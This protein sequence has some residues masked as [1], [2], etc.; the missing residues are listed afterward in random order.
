MNEIESVLSET[1]NEDLLRAFAS[2]THRLHVTLTT[3]RGDELR[4]ERA[5]VQGEILRRMSD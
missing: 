5:T 3:N 4:I 1:S 2:L